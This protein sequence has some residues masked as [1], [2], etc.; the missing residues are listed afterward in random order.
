MVD[1]QQ[2]LLT[3]PTLSEV[4]GT[5]WAAVLIQVLW[6]IVVLVG[7]FLF[8]C[9]MQPLFVK[10]PEPVKKFIREKRRCHARLRAHMPCQ[11]SG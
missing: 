7:V 2:S 10:S 5:G 3:P 1:K 11:A 8:S 4:G 9:C 6:S